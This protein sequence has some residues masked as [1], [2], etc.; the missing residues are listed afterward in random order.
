MT[1]IVA[2]MPPMDSI[3]CHTFNSNIHLPYQGQG[4]HNERRLCGMAFTPM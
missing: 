2:F 1:H 4:H 3:C